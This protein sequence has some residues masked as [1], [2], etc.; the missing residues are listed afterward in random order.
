MTDLAPTIP[1]ISDGIAPGA[2]DEPAWLADLRRA[3]L[4]VYTERGLPTVKVE[5]WKYT[6]LAGLKK[7]PFV[8]DDG[9]ARLP[10]GGDSDALALGPDDALRVT[11]VNGRLAGVPAD[12]PA[13][14][15][16]ASLA[17]LLATEPSVVEPH[18]GRIADLAD[19]PMG[20]LNAALMAD[21][22]VVLVAPG[23]VLERPLHVVSVSNTP[24]GQARHGHPR[25][26]IV[27]GDG[28]R[29]TLVESRVSAPGAAD[30]LCNAVTEIALGREARLS[31]LRHVE[32][33][34]TAVDLD[35]T[36]ATLGE[37][38]TYDTFT[39]TLGGRLVRNEARVRLRGGGASTALKGAYG[40]RAGQ[41]FDTT[42]VVDHAVPDATS[43]QVF[44]GVV[45]AG[46]KAVFQG[47]IIV[48]KDAQRT[49]GN[50][51]HKAMLL[52]RD[53][54]VYTKPELEIY[55]DD[56]T[57]SHGATV[58]ELDLNQLFYLMARGIPE[59]DARA[60]LVEAFLDDVVEAVP[61]GPLREAFLGRVR[62]WQARRHATTWETS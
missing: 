20:A 13:G 43:D 57:C 61:E 17:H 22:L 15:R 47:K 34:D 53:A 36:E 45:D 35:L 2:A 28:A 44:K 12:L 58:G 32:R 49:D 54:E 26:L 56:V 52:A 21:G 3:G 59:A 38:A 27:L 10:D 16:I 42:L 4:S 24:D 39:L 51:L 30:S 18:L 41:H 7:I 40:A 25:H 60:L 46:G 31:H 48:R 37:G 50:Q 5:A 29:A 8:L 33:A 11:L 55:A 9:R 6:S 62:A 19:A 14:V 23:T 1:L